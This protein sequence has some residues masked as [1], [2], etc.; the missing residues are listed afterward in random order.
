[1]KHINTYIKIIK[2][3]AKYLGRGALVKRVK[4]CELR[5]KF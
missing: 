5:I 2:Q 1:M 3:R 4:K